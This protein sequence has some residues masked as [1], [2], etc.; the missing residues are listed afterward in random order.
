MASGQRT[1]LRTGFLL[2]GQKLQEAVDSEISS[3]D[4]CSRLCDAVNDYSKATGTYCYFMD[5]VGDG[6][7]GDLIYCCGGDIMRAQYE[8]GSANGNATLNVD[9]DEAEDVVPHTTYEVEADDDDHYADMSEALI[10]DGLYTALPLYER[11]ISKGEREQADSGSFAGKGKSFPILKPGDVQAAV[12]AMGRAGPKNYG[13]ST[14]KANI[15]RI[16]KKKGWTKYLP[17]SWRNGDGEASESAG[18][19]YR[20]TVG[21]ANQFRAVLSSRGDELEPSVRRILGKVLSESDHDADAFLS[22][23]ARESS[24]SSSMANG[25]QRG[26]SASGPRGSGGTHGTH[27][28]QGSDIR[29]QGQRNGPGVSREKSQ[30]HFITLSES[31]TT[32][33]PIVLREAR[34]DYEI[35]LI[36][37][38]KGSSAF[39]PKE[40]LQ[41]DG[42][43][44]FKS[45]THVYLNH[46]TA[47]EESARPEGDVANLAGVLTT[48]AVYH[49]SHAKGPGLYARMKVFADHAAMVED[50]APHVGMSIRA[51]GL[52]EA[53]RT[54]DGVPVL[55]ELT[56]AESV[57]IVTRAGAN[58]M[59][60]TESAPGAR[61]G[62][63]DDMTAE[64][65]KKLIEAETRPYRDRLLKADAKEGASALLETVSLPAQAK[66]RII[67]RVLSN[68]PL[69]EGELDKDKLRESVVRE[70]KAEGEYLAS[71]TGSGRISGMG[72]S[73]P[74]LK[75]K[76]AKRMKEAAKEERKAAVAVFESLMGDHRAAKH[77][78]E[79]RTA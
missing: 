27:A 39:Y 7:S 16:A 33:E 19:L 69:K 72:P 65:A 15:I 48:D 73:E 18:S 13:M 34:A 61:T 79:G 35:R 17:K 76:E 10:R 22:W 75:P 31:A 14:L 58:G 70:A 55:K 57:D 25:H 71:V 59:I 11:F 63:A 67:E 37:P 38:G 21:T 28:S 60:L 2:V 1:V 30:E 44:V 51:M 9:W 46:P 64:E 53:N 43:K 74:A 49:E 45:G 50:K 78:A 62:A 66:Q 24:Q 29:E 5:Y 42:P 41:R 4:V 23:L 54:K 32:L 20:D 6:E 36:A 12:H 26:T 3:K 40:V 56:S 47:A 77:A 52:P 68:I 8:M